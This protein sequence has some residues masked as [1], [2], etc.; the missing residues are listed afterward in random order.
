MPVSRRTRMNVQGGPWFFGTV[1]A[2]TNMILYL[3]KP[4]SN[5][6]FVAVGAS[7]EQGAGNIDL[8]LIGFNADGSIAWQKFLG[9]SSSENP[10]YGNHLFVD[11]GGNI[12]ATFYTTITG[13]ALVVAKWNSAG[14]LQWQSYYRNVNDA[15]GVVADSSGNVYACGYDA[16]SGQAFVTKFNSS[17]VWQSAKYFNSAGASSFFTAMTIDAADGIYIGGRRFVSGS[18]NTA[19]F[20][21][22]TT[23]LVL[24]WQKALTLATNVT[25]VLSSAVDSSN[26]V[27]FACY[28]ASNL[29]WLLTKHNSSGALQWQKKFT[30]GANASPNAMFIDSDNLL[31]YVG[32]GTASGTKRLIVCLDA[33]GALQFQRYLSNTNLQGVC[34]SGQDMVIS[35][36]NGTGSFGF[37]GKIPKDGSKLGTFGSYVYSA[38]A[39]T[40]AT[41]TIHTDSTPTDSLVAIPTPIN[42][43]STLTTTTGT[44]TASLTGVF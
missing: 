43:S 28:D 33:T 40:L 3:T 17:G 35:G 16:T 18:E 5:G 26:N 31:Y 6:G 21:K 41:N 25:N 9:N 36:L 37:I 4:T 8:F 44:R 2:G 29:W 1:G 42:G 19:F 11:A 12:Y 30:L 39:G 13:T 10:R 23:A 15:G 24:T 22:V 7:S 27:Y 38:G 14:T 20:I 34:V 32:Y